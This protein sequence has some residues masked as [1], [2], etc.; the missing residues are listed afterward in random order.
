MAVDKFLYSSVPKTTVLNTKHTSKEFFKK[1][2][3][4]GTYLIKHTGLDFLKI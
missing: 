1:F 2:K 4:I 3:N